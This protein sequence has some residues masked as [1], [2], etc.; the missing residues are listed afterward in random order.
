MSIIMLLLLV[1]RYVRAQSRRNRF[2]RRDAQ[3]APRLRII[4]A[5]LCLPPQLLTAPLC[6]T[7]ASSASCHV[8]LRVLCC[9][10]AASSASSIIRCRAPCIVRPAAP[11]IIR[12]AAPSTIRSVP[13]QDH[14]AFEWEQQTPGPLQRGE[15]NPEAQPQQAVP[16]ISVRDRETA[17]K[18]PCG[19]LSR[20]RRTST[21]QPKQHHISSIF[22]DYSLLIKKEQAD[23]SAVVLP[24]VPALRCDHSMPSLNYEHE[25]E[26]E[27]FRCEI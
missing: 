22:D 15:A 9:V 11:S 1:I 16:E 3:I 12:P 24:L 2:R 25:D 27:N 21:R 13:Q 7:A 19:T 4:L 8:L 18:A 6:V 5:P 10:T 23:S 20:C 26:R 17:R 14:H